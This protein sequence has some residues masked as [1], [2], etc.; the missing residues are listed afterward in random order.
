LRGPGGAIN[1]E[2]T[3]FKELANGRVEISGSVFEPTKEYFIKLE[4]A[5]QVGFRTISV[6]AT[7]DPV[8]IREIDTILKSV[9]EQVDAFLAKER[10]KGSV[11]FIVYGK[12]GVMG[13]MEPLRNPVSHE[14][15]IVINAVG[16]T[17]AAADSLCGLT[18][19]S[20]LHYGYKGRI[21]TAGNLAFPFSPSDAKMG[22]VYEF[23]LYHLMPLK[24]QDI[25]RKK[26][27]KVGK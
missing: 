1:L 5:R 7:R 12:N 19:S 27:V 6:A 26:I 11:Q 17:Q 21:S 18:R 10:I 20:L 3:E 15:G 25:F 4:G 22:E 9:E 8:M 14:L 24:N 23:S 2:K 16:E 13:E